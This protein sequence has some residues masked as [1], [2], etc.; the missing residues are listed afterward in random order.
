MVNVAL[1]CVRELVTVKESE[2]YITY[3]PYVHMRLCTRE[4]GG[5]GIS[6]ASRSCQGGE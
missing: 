3:S 5:R 2:G 4:L 1:G 6:I